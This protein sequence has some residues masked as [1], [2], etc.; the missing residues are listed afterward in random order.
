[1]GERSC[2]REAPGPVR[3]AWRNHRRGRR[4]AGVLLGLL[5]LVLG[6]CSSLPTETAEP[7]Q[8]GLKSQAADQSRTGDENLAQR[9]YP[10]A[11]DYYRRSY[12]YNARVDNLEGMSQAR[13]SLGF[14]YLSL[15]RVPEAGEAYQEALELALLGDD[16]RLV[17][18]G[19]I[20]LAKVA[21]AAKEPARALD[22]LAKADAA[23]AAKKADGQ[24]VNIDDMKALILHNRAVALRDTGKPD[25]ALKLLAEAL[26]INQARGLLR[27]T[28][29]NH[30][31][32]A[33]ILNQQGLRDDA[34][35]HL[36]LSLDLDKKAEAH[37]AIP[38]DLYA[39]ARVYQARNAAGD[40][41]LARAHAWRAFQ[42]AL[43]NNDSALVRK[44]LA[45]LAELDAALGRTADLERWQLYLG[46]LDS[47]ASAP[48]AGSQAGTSPVQET[49]KETK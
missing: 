38:G 17:V 10:L 37:D 13:N 32:M 43:A 9:N 3:G 12:E 16:P 40:Q 46:R 42:S 28:A 5:G 24:P 25:E 1:M 7:L 30:Y 35:V 8:M 49:D 29:S 26:A 18:L 45:S 44:C 23:G 11:E 2:C 31:L 20:N 33:A 34:L 15:G 39:I 14:L 48:A 4:P 27:E 19:W 47:P 6:A 41:E 36:A 21:L 22:C